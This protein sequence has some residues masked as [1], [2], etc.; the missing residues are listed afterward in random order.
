MERVCVFIDGS[1]FYFALKRNFFKTKVD[2]Y[3]LAKALTGQD[4][5]LVKILYYNSAYDPDT[6]PELFQN[7]KSFLGALEKVPNLQLRLG[8]IVQNGA[9]TFTEKGTDVLFSADII[10]YAAKDLFDTAIIFAEEDDFAYPMELVKGMGKNV[11]L[12]HFRDIKSRE[13]IKASDNFIS[14]EKVFEKNADIFIPNVEKVVIPIQPIAETVVEPVKKKR[15]RPK[16]KGLM[17]GLKKIME[18]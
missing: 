4:R 15:G 7:Q 8:K 17:D 9:G 14:L 6:A 16:T 5:Q 2:Y 1:R 13:I 12:C 10:Y 11:E 18:A 3:K